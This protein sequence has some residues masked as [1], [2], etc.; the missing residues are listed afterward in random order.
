[1]KITSKEVKEKILSF[2]KINTPKGSSKPLGLGWSLWNSF[3]LTKAEST[4]YILDDSIPA[5]MQKKCGTP[6]A[7]RSILNNALEAHPDLSDLVLNSSS[8]IFL[9]IK[10]M[11]ISQ[12][13]YNEEISLE[14][15]VK[16]E[17]SVKCEYLKICNIEDV[18]TFFTDKNE[19]V[20]I[21]AY[22]RYGI[23]S[24]AVKMIKDKSAKVRLTACQ[25]LPNGHPAFDSL[26]NDRSKWVFCFVVKKIN[27]NKLPL[28]L[29]NNHM[30]DSFI[31]DLFK[32]RMMNIGET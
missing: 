18:S 29:S 26:I 11:I 27:K 17:P 32:K 14:K 2:I 3:H 16:L 7:Y 13:L 20:R 22:K 8:R 28:L 12:G 23:L 19:R 25:S 21:E 4:A 6:Y 31:K 15:I 24:S 5:W 1:M 9:E 30:K 10:P